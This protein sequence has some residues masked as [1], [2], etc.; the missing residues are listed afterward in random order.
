MAGAT[1]GARTR[2]VVVESPAKIKSIA[3]FLG[4]GYVVESS[5]GHIRDLPSK[6][7][8]VPAEKRDRYG[9][10]VGVDVNGDFEPLYI[11][12]SSRA[13]EQVR[14][15]KSLLKDADEL[16]LATDGDREGEAIA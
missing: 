15:L 12:S 4:D 13:K 9:D 10:P 1:K 8:E 7:T 6:K 14:K 3:G 11:V 2:L 5:F 16:L